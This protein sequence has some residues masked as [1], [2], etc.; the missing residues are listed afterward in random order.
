MSKVAELLTKWTPVV[1]KKVGSR[2]FLRPKKAKRSANYITF[3]F[4]SGPKKPKLGQKHGEKLEKNKAQNIFTNLTL[5]SLLQT[6][7]FA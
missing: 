4:F 5:F 2:Q 7:Q 1:Q 3:V 6:G